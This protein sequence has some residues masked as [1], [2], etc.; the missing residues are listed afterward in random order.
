MT[1]T[2]SPAAACMPE[3]STQQALRSAIASHEKAIKHHRHASLLYERGD[4]RQANTHASIACAHAR[5]ALASGAFLLA[6][7]AQRLEP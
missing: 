6:D 2:L 5:S 4:T 3:P 7:D 1:H